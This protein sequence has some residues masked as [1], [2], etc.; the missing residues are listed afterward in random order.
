MEAKGVV[1]R[2]NSGKA[3][4]T[5]KKE[6][7]ISPFSKGGLL[8]FLPLPRK[9]RA[10]LRR[11]ILISLLLLAVQHYLREWPSQCSLFQKEEGSF[12]AERE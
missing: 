4:T 12:M 2:R 3:T 10:G 1:G 7:A 6:K 8:L 5:A 9:G 11:Q